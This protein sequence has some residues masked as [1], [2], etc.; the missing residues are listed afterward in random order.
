[1]PFSS[2]EDLANPGREPGSLALQVDS[3]LTEPPGKAPESV[4]RCAY[5]RD[6]YYLLRGTQEGRS[7]SVVC[8]RSTTDVSSAGAQFVNV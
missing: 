1:M 6:H 4:E 3:L 8:V 5:V 2:P 7:V